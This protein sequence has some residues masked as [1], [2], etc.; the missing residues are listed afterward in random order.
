MK[1]QADSLWSLMQ[2]PQEGTCSNG[3]GDVTDVNDG[4]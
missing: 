2:G 3:D 1:I 4:E